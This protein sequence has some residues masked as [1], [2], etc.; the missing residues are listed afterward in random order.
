MYIPN[1]PQTDLIHL[2]ILLFY[3]MPFIS[4]IVFPPFLVVLAL[5]NLLETKSL[6]CCYNMEITVPT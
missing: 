5:P 2:V 3:L 4:Y 1:E 6:F